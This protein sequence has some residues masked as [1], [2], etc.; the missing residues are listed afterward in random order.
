MGN[1]DHGHALFCQRLD[2]LQYLAD[3]LRVQRGCGLIEQQQLRLHAERPGNGYTLLLAAG[4]LCRSGV[5]VSAHA[6]L[7]QIFFRGLLRLCLILFVDD[8]HADHAV[9]QHVHVGK[10]VEGLE[11][12]TYFGTELVLILRFVGNLFSLEHDLA[13]G[14]FL[15][16]IDTA[17]QCGF[18]GS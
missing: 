4:Q 9:F 18:T 16:H 7:F 6:H 12:H 11:Y 3:H 10:Q 1:D 2:N 5:D 15:Q 8:L 17:E 13:A 14:G